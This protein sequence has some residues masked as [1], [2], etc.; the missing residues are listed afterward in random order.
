VEER[1]NLQKA[2]FELEDLNIM[3]T[4]ELRSIRDFYASGPLIPAP[5]WAQSSMW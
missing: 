1:I 5:C 2:L 4:A 3:H